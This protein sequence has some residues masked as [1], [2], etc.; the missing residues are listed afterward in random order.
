[1]EV[2]DISS[3]GSP[4]GDCKVDVAVEG[5]PPGGGLVVVHVEDSLEVKFKT[6]CEAFRPW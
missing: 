5:T 2:D 3:V 1:M 6:F 4:P